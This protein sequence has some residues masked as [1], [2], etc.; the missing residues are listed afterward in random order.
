MRKDIYQNV[1]DRIIKVMEDG[2]D[3][4]SEMWNSVQNMFPLRESG[5]PYKGI[6]TIL[7][8]LSSHE[9]DYKS[10][11]WMTY[12]QS[13]KLKG[14]VRKG[15]KSTLVVYWGTK[16]HNEGQE[17]EKITRFLKGYNVFNTDQI[18]NLSEKYYNKSEN[19]FENSDERISDIEDFVKNV[20]VEIFDAETP[21]Y[22]IDN[23]N[24]GMPIFQSFKDATSYY[25]VLNH[26]LVHWTGPMLKRD[27]RNK[28]K[29]VYAKEE[30][31]AELG[32]SFLCAVQGIKSDIK[33][34]SGYLNHWLKNLKN[35]K[36]FIFEAASLAQK[37]SDYLLE[38]GQWKGN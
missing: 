12:K 6:N 9:N 10:Q 1:T 24:I 31:I 36:K 26:E 14:Q 11:Y 33:D 2:N 28:P 5:E 13:Q 30:L 29:E 17:N 20:G 34:H 37:A 23:H 25:S 22:K 38:K 15:E 8:S 3:S 27:M 32:A 7:L 16:I 21:H 35:D 4:W 19:I 18:D